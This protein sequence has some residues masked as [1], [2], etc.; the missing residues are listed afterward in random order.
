MALS[1]SSAADVQ[2]LSNAEL[3][4]FVG[5]CWCL[6]DDTILHACKDDICVPYPGYEYWSAKWED[7]DPLSDDCIFQTRYGGLT[8]IKNGGVLWCGRDTGDP[9]DF[10][11]W[12]VWHNT[13]CDGIYA[14]FDYEA[15][16]SV[17]EDIG[18]LCP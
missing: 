6:T 5:A 8:C 12:K 10:G 3:G 11:T 7:P 14:D 9:A 1:I 4:S 16:K 17:T 15:E 13:T 2:A 18:D